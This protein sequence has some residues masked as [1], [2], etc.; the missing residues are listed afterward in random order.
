MESSP[1]RL[2]LAHVAQKL[3]HFLFMYLSLSLSLFGCRFV[4]L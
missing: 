1:R 2:L 3:L 4:Y